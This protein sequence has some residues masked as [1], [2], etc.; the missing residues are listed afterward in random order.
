MLNIKQ[1]SIVFL[2]LFL[3][4][5]FMMMF[6][7][8]SHTQGLTVALIVAF[9]SLLFSGVSKKYITRANPL[10]FVLILLAITLHGLLVHGLTN[11]FDNQKFIGSLILLP[12]LYAV[13][14]GLASVA[15]QSSDK[16]FDKLIVICFYTFLLIGILGILKI[17]PF[18][19]GYK[20]VFFFSEPSHFARPFLP[21]LAYMAVTRK[22][23]SRI[24][25]ILS[26]LILGAL[27]ENLTLVVGLV[28]VGLLFAKK[29][30]L[31]TILV[32]FVLI[33]ILK[34]YIDLDYF[35]DRLNF[36]S[37][38]NNLSSLVYLQGWEGALNHLKGSYFMG[39]GFQ[40]YGLNE[41]ASE[42]ELRIYDII[43]GQLNYNDGSFMA[44]KIIGEFG[45]FG[46]FALFGFSIVWFK[47]AKALASSVDIRRLEYVNPQ[48]L[49]FSCVF[50]C[51]LT[52]FFVRG[53]GY[54]NAP[55][56]LFYVAC[57]FKMVETKSEKLSRFRIRFL[58]KKA[59]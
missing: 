26:G 47:S 51:A 46:L 28:F 33:L 59:R 24:L 44:A 49:F 50:F 12:L 3:P 39:Y 19:G 54:F 2:L 22:G 30:S 23:V 20:E 42:A 52:D 5:S 57:I 56:T 14:A 41:I 18:N 27:L 58:S 37:D 38:G 11:N 48:S 7:T 45:V 10:L 16:S 6:N 13:S 29:R 53:S 43:Q 31:V 35:I 36:S 55:M 8:S 40:Q 4:S 9:F 21:F 1:V 15:H 34:N 25:F 32:I 17:S